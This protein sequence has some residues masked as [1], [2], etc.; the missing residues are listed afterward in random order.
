M[1]KS[2]VTKLFIAALIA[3]AAG[4]VAAVIALG[5][6]LASDVFV[7]SGPVVVTVNES[8]LA[9][10]LLAVGLAGGLAIT[11]GA[12]AGF[13]SWIGALLNTAQL[14]SKMWFLALLLL[15]IFNLGFIAMIAYLIAGP[16][17]TRPITP[18]TAPAP[19]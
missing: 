4:T 5:A 18:V 11:G 12:I 14:P 1:S 17:S 13:V 9:F 3:L 16:D 6:A 2:T 15:G 7:M 8:P 10:M 19:A